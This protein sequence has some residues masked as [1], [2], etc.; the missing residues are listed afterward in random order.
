[1]LGLSFFLVA[2]A[3]ALAQN[4]PG[5]LLRHTF[6]DDTS[7]W[8]VMG[9]SGSVRVA[10]GALQ[11]SYEVKPK[12]LAVAVL[13]APAETAQM[14]RLR[15]RVKTD[16]DTA[17]A[18]LLSERKP[19][20]GNYLATFWCAAGAWQPVEL[21]P[22]DFAAADG[23]ND[24][25]D[26]DG[27]LDLDQLDGIGVLD[28]ASFFSSQPE[29]TDFPVN[30]DLTSCRHTLQIAGFEMLSNSA[31]SARAALA[32][33]GFDRGYV[34]WITLGGVTLKLAGTDNPL[35]E[36]ALEA[37]YEQTQGHYGLLLRRL[38]NLDLS[39]ATG[40]AFDIASKVD[41][42]VIVSLE[43]KNGR[44]FHQTIYPPTAREM[45][46][47]QLKFGDFE[48]DGKLDPAQLK[49]LGIADISAAE[50]AAGPNTLWIG[51]VEGTR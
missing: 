7:G 29:N 46:H 44:R 8:L 6:A 36:G 10:D 34:E 45:L 28:L 16:H 1:M 17:I 5:V 49:S 2:A 38:S 39:K 23:P 21:T 42:T 50:G 18:V 15:F 22:S 41:A 48:G 20:G 32:I 35:K 37:H 25:V 9:Q 12:Q 3:V 4:Q 27:K 43:L 33:D 26:A 19:G 51:K 13:P 40:L 30:I 11:F 47:V 24:P 14:K 31:A